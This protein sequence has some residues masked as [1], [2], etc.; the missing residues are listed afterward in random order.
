MKN[1]VKRFAAVLAA[2]MMTASAAGAS[3]YADMEI[4]EEQ[5]KSIWLK[6]DDG[7]RYF[8]SDGKAAAGK[9]YKIDGVVYDFSNSGYELGKHAGWIKENGVSRR[10]NDGL[11]YTGWVQ[12][13]KTGTYNYCLDG[14]KVTGDHQTDDKIY[15]FDDKG[16][17]TGVSKVPALTAKCDDVVSSDSDVI[18]LTVTGTD[19]EKCFGEPYIMERWEN[20]NW[21]EVEHRSVHAAYSTLKRS[22]GSKSFA[23]SPQKYKNLAEGYYRIAFQSWDEDNFEETKENF[24][25]VFEVVPPITVETSEEVYL[26]DGI[27]DVQVKT[28]VTINSRGL[29]E[30]YYSHTD[31]LGV[32]IMYNDRVYGWMSYKKSDEIEWESDLY[33]EGQP[34]EIIFTDSVPAVNLTGHNRVIITTKDGK[35][36]SD[37]RID[38][39]RAEIWLEEYSLKSD[40]LTICFTVFNETEKSCRIDTRIYQFEEFKNDNWTVVDGAPDIEASGY[41]WET[42][43][44]GQR[45]TVE[46]PLSDYY[47]VSALKKGKY[48]VLI[49]NYGYVYFD[50]VDDES[51]NNKTPYE[52]LSMDAVEKIELHLLRGEF[53][54]QHETAVFTGNDMR[55]PMTYLKQLWVGDTIKDPDIADGSSFYAVIFYKDGSEEKIIFIENNVIVYKENYKSCSPYIYGALKDLLIEALDLDENFYGYRQIN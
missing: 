25:A 36:K 19:M 33:E 44:K 42:L 5:Y 23:F 41:S 17:Y 53:P 6:N 37:F 39:L 7:W 31:E 47:D 20:G 12:S 38:R 3:V 9:P 29:A 48:R 43:E 10:Y 21:A 32:D 45:I 27:H 8:L 24:Y 54:V 34:L 4:E 40:D 11:P 46:F 14:Y 52:K 18:N 30:Y 49:E 28:I 35:C 2:A 1:L 15:S 22:G 55:R 16:I 50:L 51:D 26:F 13:R